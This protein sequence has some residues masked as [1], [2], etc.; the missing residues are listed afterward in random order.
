MREDPF[1]RYLVETGDYKTQTIKFLKRIKAKHRPKELQD[2]AQKLLDAHKNDEK[3][4]YLPHSETPAFILELD[5]PFPPFV[6]VYPKSYVGVDWGGGF[7]HWGLFL[8]S[9]KRPNNP[10]LFVIEWVPG[11]YAYHTNT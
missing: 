10:T 4:F 6:T 1:Y 9:S 8:A 7:G 11:L 2:W 5:P 3:P